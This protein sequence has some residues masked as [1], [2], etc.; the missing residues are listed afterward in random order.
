MNSHL[1][2]LEEGR[3]GGGPCL[4]RLSFFFCVLCKRLQIVALAILRRA[5][6]LVHKWGHK[7]KVLI[8]EKSNRIA[9]NPPAAVS[10]CH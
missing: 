9:P 6:I 8:C 5:V 3:E 1:W 4:A 7:K 2:R 10:D